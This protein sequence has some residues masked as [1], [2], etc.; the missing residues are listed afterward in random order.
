[1]KTDPRRARRSPHDRDASATHDGRN[2]VSTDAVAPVESVRRAYD[3][4]SLFYDRLAAPW[5][6]RACLRGLELAR[7]APTDRVLEVAVGPGLMTLEIL[8]RV[9]RSNIVNGIDLSPGMLR[10]ARCRVS[11]SGYPNVDLRVG[12]ARLLPYEDNRFDVLYNGFM[13]DLIPSG[14][15]PQVLGEFRRVLK[16]DG[17]LVLVCMS[18]RRADRRTWF[19]RL[20]QRLPRAWVPYLLGSCRPVMMAPLVVQAG[21]VRVRRE[22]VRTVFFPAEVVTARRAER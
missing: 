5:E 11:A 12:D 9:E 20:Y 21:F 1:M 15:L 17:R 16:P 4:F 6:R 8:R 10:K 14:E 7:I 3:F 22:V 19:E 13:L 18:K 2:F